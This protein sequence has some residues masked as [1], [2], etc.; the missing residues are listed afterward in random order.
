MITSKFPPGTPGRRLFFV[1][2][3]APFASLLLIAILGP[4]FGHTRAWTAIYVTIAAVAFAI[5]TPCLL[6]AVIRNA[7]PERSGGQRG[8]R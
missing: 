1:G 7:R 8:M 3:A 4:A 6:L 2:A 5:G